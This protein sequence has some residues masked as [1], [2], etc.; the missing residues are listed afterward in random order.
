[1]ASG[2]WRHAEPDSSAPALTLSLPSVPTSDLLLAIGDGDNSPLALATAELLLQSVHVRFFRPGPGELR[3]VYGRSALAA[4]RYDLALLAPTVLASSA[5]E[6]TLSVE[7]ET[8]QSEP[9]ILRPRAFW[10]LMLSAV[11]VLLVLI[12][13]LVRGAEARRE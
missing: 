6:A 13:R 1:V 9:V 11:V 10:A 5:L 7:Q 12:A 8:T 2:T 3:V 4:P